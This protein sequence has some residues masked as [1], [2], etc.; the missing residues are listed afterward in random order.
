MLRL[1]SRFLRRDFLSRR[2]DFLCRD[3][4]SRRRDFLSRRLLLGILVLAFVFTGPAAAQATGLEEIHPDPS[5]TTDNKTYLPLI[6]DQTTYL[7]QGRVTS[8][9]IPVPGLQIDMWFTTDYWQTSTKF[10][11][12]VTDAGGYYGFGELPAAGPGTRMGVEWV[13]PDD[14]YIWP[15]LSGFMC[16]EADISFPSYDNTCDFDI[17]DVKLIEPA[18]DAAVSL[19]ATFRWIPQTMGMNWYLFYVWDPDLRHYHEGP[20]MPYTD[21]YTLTS[22]PSYFLTGFP[23]NWS[24]DVDTPDGIG[25]SYWYRWVSFNNLGSFAPELGA[26]PTAGLLSGDGSFR[27]RVTRFRQAVQAAPSAAAP[28]D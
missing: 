1:C 11:T 12:V 19:P 21:N 26:S 7:Y 5:L 16:D 28:G 22:V 15:Y 18:H 13:N 27:T 2:R 9:G 8:Q 3:F 23:Y 17:E 14:A 6:T 25:I 20:L 24:V 4:L 10:A